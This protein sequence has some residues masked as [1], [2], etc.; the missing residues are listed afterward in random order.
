MT[1]ANDVEPCGVLR[2][3]VRRTSALDLNQNDLQSVSAP[4]SPGR[5]TMILANRYQINYAA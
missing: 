2:C 3:R 5:F 4:R 1:T